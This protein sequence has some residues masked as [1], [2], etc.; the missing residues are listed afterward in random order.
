MHDPVAAPNS[1]GRRPHEINTVSKAVLPE[2]QNNVPRTMNALPAA[3]QSG[4][5]LHLHNGDPG[6]LHKLLIFVV[7]ETPTSGIRKTQFRNAVSLI[8]RLFESK[9]PDVLR[10]PGP[11]FSGSMQSLAELLTCSESSIAYPCTKVNGVAINSGTVTGR[12][13][14]VTFNAIFN[15]GETSPGLPGTATDTNKHQRKIIFHTLQEYDENAEALFLKFACERDYQPKRIAVLSEDETA[16][17]N[18]PSG[19]SA[20]KSANCDDPDSLEPAILH[21]YFPR[22]ISQLLRGPCSPV[23]APPPPVRDAGCGGRPPPGRGARPA[24]RPAPLA[25][26]AVVRRAVRRSACP[27]RPGP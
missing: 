16:Y 10:I 4:E 14:V 8:D 20:G 24:P 6:V 15:P 2:P 9:P 21:M 19:Q 26:R 1:Q 13:S 5:H 3:S 7:A 22:E 23:R 18:N 27:I 25:Q 12:D 17:G 11:T